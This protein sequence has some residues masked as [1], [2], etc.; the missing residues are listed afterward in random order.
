M[1]V[2]EVDENYSF[3]TALSTG[4]NLPVCYRGET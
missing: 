1:A 3:R 2:Q 4:A